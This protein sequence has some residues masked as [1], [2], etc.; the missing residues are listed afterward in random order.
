MS[1]TFE[2]W[3]DSL[4]HARM[5]NSYEYAEQTW[6]HQQKKISSLQDQLQWSLKNEEKYKKLTLDNQTRYNGALAEIKDLEKQVAILKEAVEFIDRENQS[7]TEFHCCD[8][9][10]NNCG[11][12][13]RETLKQ[14]EEIEKGE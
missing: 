2:E 5:V 11:K 7:C 8:D 4:D 12:K 14:I 10:L 9:A 13:A 1:K 3:F 6:N